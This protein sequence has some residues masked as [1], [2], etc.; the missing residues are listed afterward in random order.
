MSRDGQK[1]DPAA[2]AVGIGVLSL[3]LLGQVLDRLREPRDRKA[4][5]LVSRAFERAEAAHRRALRAL[6]REPLPRLL[7]ASPALERLDLSACA[8]LDDASLAAA[9]AGGL[10]GLR[11]VCLARASGVGWRG[12]DALVAACPKLEAVDLSHC[13]GAGDR[14]AAALAAAARLRDRRLDKCLAVTDMGLA[15]V[16]VGRPRLEK[17]SFKWCR[18][19]SD[20]GID[21]LAKKCRD[22]RSLDI[23]YLEVTTTATTILPYFY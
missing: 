20:I 12:L 19:I 21:L 9:V 14:E 10:A 23:S 18:E 22:L 1:L 17:L 5:R 15:K 16:A 4:C 13:V 6:R 3:D 11:S 8:S 7:R 2:G